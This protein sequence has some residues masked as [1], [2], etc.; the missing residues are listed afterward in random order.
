[1]AEFEPW[2]C[3]HTLDR[4]PRWAHR[5]DRGYSDAALRHQVAERRLWHLIGVAATISHMAGNQDYI[6]D[7]MR[8]LLEAA[9][10]TSDDHDARAVARL[11][12]AS[13]QI[14]DL[15]VDGEERTILEADDLVAV[16]AFAIW[17]QKSTR[18]GPPAQYPSQHP[19]SHDEFPAGVAALLPT[20]EQERMRL[21]NELD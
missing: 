7:Q 4:R 16:Y 11:E 1:M 6:R 13:Q 2:P 20:F 14:L 3:D 18:P 21:L 12:N 8:I 10:R 5:V 15:M 17:V 19:Q 9:A